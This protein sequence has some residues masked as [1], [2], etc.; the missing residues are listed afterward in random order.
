MRYLISKT[1]GYVSAWFEYYNIHNSLQ[2][3]NNRELRD[4]GIS[5]SD[6]DRI[7]KNTYTDR[8]TNV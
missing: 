7:A 2:K 6:I 4:M 1:I 3:M 8:I 5:R